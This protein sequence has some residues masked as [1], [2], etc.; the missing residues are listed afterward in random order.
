MAKKI[1]LS[2]LGQPQLG[3]GFSYNISISGTPIVYEN[4]LSA[5]N[6]KYRA[7]RLGNLSPNKIERQLSL[8]NTIDNTFFFL[9]NN[10]TYS[11]VFYVRKNNTIEVIINTSLPINI[12]FGSFDPNIT[13]SVLEIPETENINLKYFFQYKNI[14]NDEYRCE[15]YNKQYFG[16]AT[17]IKGRAT[18]EK[19]SV[20][21]HLEPIRGTGLLLD[22]EASTTLTLEDLYTENEQ[23]F[24]VRLYKN[25]KVVFIGFLKP[26][27]IY[28][29]FTRDIWTISMDCIDGLGAI[30]NLSFVQPNGFRFIGKM[31]AIDIIYNCLRRTG[32]SL[33]I[34]TSI[35][36]VYDGLVRS[37]NMDV[38]TKVKMNADRFFRIDGQGTGDGTIMSCEEVLKSVLDV[39]CA[40]ITQESGEWY[41]YKTNELFLTDYP[42]F[43]RYNIQNVYNGNVTLNIAE[44]LGSQINNFYPYHCSGNQKID[45][46][47]AV[48]AFRINY[49]YG[50]VDGL[51]V[52]NSLQ[53][54]EN[55]NYSGWT[56]NTI[57]NSFLVKDPL[58]SSGLFM[59]SLDPPDATVLILTSSPIAIKEGGLFDFKASLTTYGFS[60]DY[61]FKIKLGSYRLISN[62]E[63]V[64]TDSFFQYTLGSSAED[65]KNFTE[66]S[67]TFNISSSPAPIEGVMYI[68]IYRPKNRLPPFAVSLRPMVKIRSVDITTNS[69]E[70]KTKVGEFH[71]VSRIS[72]VSSIVKENKSVSNGDRS[73][74]F[75]LGTIFKEDGVLD[76]RTWSRKGSFESYPLLRIAAED[77]LRLGQKP[78]K[79]FSGNIFG[80]LPYLSFLQINSING[81]FFPIE[82]SYD[83]LNN[84]IKLKVLELYAEEIPDIMY[85]FSFDYGNTVK[86]TIVG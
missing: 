43:R 10:Y 61:L 60:T 7:H 40:C 75:Y 37:P 45:I 3:N 53:H 56:K 4:G 66:I 25:G 13:Q 85:K 81:R 33:P 29:S 5:L 65:A 69:A 71:T 67:D 52:N 59:R 9:A 63:W 17:E 34:N 57:S 26:D 47:G 2:F 76:T 15:I 8:A 77:E 42:L 27:G 55:L 62:G 20:K 70:L 84:Q 11:N 1:I 32:I 82:Y 14:V 49:K 46:K 35:N 78:L 44:V 18:I 39:F 54:D 22:L 6:V 64:T 73:E 41:I 86:P 79:V 80:F 28:Q 68:E 16:N 72:K 19:G 21:D 48:S 50:F 74:N 83:T 23:D 36:T 30:S 51:L 58:S 31:S 38:L 24:T 12:S